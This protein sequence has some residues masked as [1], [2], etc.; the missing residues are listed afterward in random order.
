MI[1][2]ENLLKWALRFYPPMFVQRI[3]VQKFGKGFTSVEV[4]INKS[5]FNKNFNNSIFGG[6]L[7]SA[8]DPFHVIMFDQ[9]L[10]RRGYKVRSWLKSAQIEYIKPGRSSLYFKITLTEEDIATAEQILSTV[11]K[12]IKSFPVNMYDKSGELCVVMMAE[13]YIRNLHLGENRIAAY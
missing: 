13:V 10:N 7:F 5:I 6:T 11:G 9:I 8:A 1:V 2:S 3:W 4:K 12:Y